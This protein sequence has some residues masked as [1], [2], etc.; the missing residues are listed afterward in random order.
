MMSA[1]SQDYS[2]RNERA[3]AQRE[4]IL[5][6][7]QKCFIEHGFH[8]ASMAS[9]AE[10]AQMSPGLIYR[11]F[12]NK[13]AI[14]LAI[15]ARQ[16]EEKQADIASLQGENELAPRIRALFQSW[17]SGDRNVMSAPLFLEMTAEG[18]RDPHIAGALCA[19]DELTRA[20]FSRW[21]L[22]RKSSAGKTI[23]EQ[24]VQWRAFALQCF[25]EWL[26]IRA[27]RE[28][29]LDKNLLEQ[30]LKELLPILLME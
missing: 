2:R 15:I 18:S 27:I 16:L 26:A 4:R 20:E 24:E 28:P 23:L 7:A 10:A 14:I 21:L 5:C 19:A 11:Y 22:Q 30:S 8:A 12:D 29:G 3:Q 1:S 13:S 9:I 6:A 17:Q 25:I